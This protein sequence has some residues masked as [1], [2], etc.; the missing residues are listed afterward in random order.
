[1]IH[2]TIVDEVRAIREEI[3]REHN[4]DLDAIFRT[5]QRLEAQSDWPHV[6][7][8]PRRFSADAEA[9]TAEPGTATAATARA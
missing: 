8:S 6:S 5:L 2:D 4:Y 9:G 1:M 3:A 7:L